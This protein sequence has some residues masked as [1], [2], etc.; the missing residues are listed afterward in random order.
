LAGASAHASH[1]Q[2]R[3]NWEP[4]ATKI[5]ADGG[6]TGHLGLTDEPSKTAAGS[7]NT[8]ITNIRAFSTA[9]TAS[10][11]VFNHANFSFTLQL[12]DLAS[13]ATGTVNFS[14]FFSGTLTANN[15]NIKANFTSPTTETAS[16][17]GNTFTVT[18]GTYT[19]PGPPGVANAGSLN[20]TVTVKP[21]N[22]GGGGIG[23]PEPSTL[24]L[25]ALALPFTGLAGWRRRKRG[26]M[27]PPP[28]AL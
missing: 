11:D 6:G 1:I 19:P 2:W 28:C 20:A 3:Y 14:G 21:G 26:S 5:V 27:S 13:A 23:T 15:A 16:L 12:K 22:G 18:L 24:T 10:P 9:T 17:G 4:S 7:S 25:A 8:V